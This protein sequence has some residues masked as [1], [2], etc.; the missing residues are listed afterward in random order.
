MSARIAASRT[1]YT[2]RSPRRRFVS[3]AAAGTK[4]ISNPTR[5][6]NTIL[7]AMRPSRNRP[8]PPRAVAP[9]KRPS[10]RPPAR[11]RARAATETRAAD[12]QFRTWKLAATPPGGPRH[13]QVCVDLCGGGNGVCWRRDGAGHLQQ[14]AAASAAGELLPEPAAAGLRPSARLRPAD[15]LLRQSAVLLVAL[16][17]VVRLGWRARRPADCT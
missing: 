1:R 2:G 5:K 4:P 16:P 7:P 15:R 14:P 6:R 8:N 11:P 9:A 13:A 17:A 10:P 3:P 12:V